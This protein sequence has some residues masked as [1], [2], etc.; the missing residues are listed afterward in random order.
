[1]FI[2]KRDGVIHR[3][4]QYI[5]NVF[6]LKGDLEN[7]LFKPFSIT[8][9]AYQMNICHKLHFNGYLPIALTGLTTSAI[10]IKT[11]MLRFIAAYIRKLLEG[12][13][14]SNIVVS[15]NIGHGIAPTGP[16]NGIL[17]YKLNTFNLFEIPTY[18]RKLTWLFT[19]ATDFPEKGREK[20]FSHQ[21][22]LPASRN[23]GYC[24]K[25]I[26]GK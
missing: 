10:Y 15:L 3:H 5:V 26:Q 2:K 14:I 11:E 25:G 18:F 13:Q 1:M 4:S 6:V 23:T 21:S 9:I 20:D 7:F 22:T 24:R 12:E 17:V 16:A 19:I 8:D